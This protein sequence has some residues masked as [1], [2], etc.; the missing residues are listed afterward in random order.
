[1]M[2]ENE[3]VTK[4]SYE[5]AI[6][7]IETKEVMPDPDAPSCE[8]YRLRPSEEAAVLVKNL[9]NPPPP[10][11]LKISLA[12]S[13]IGAAKCV[14]IGRKLIL[15]KTV[16]YLDLSMC[17]L[18]GGAASFFS[19]LAKNTTLRH[20]SVNGNYIGDEGAVAASSSLSHLESLHIASNGISDKGAKHLSDALRNSATLKILNI[21]NNSL[22]LKGLVPFLLA[23]EPCEDTLPEGLKEAVAEAE[24]KKKMNTDTDVDKTGVDD[25]DSEDV[26]EKDE[27]DEEQSV[28]EVKY[29]TIL[30]TLWIEGNEEVTQ[31]LKDTLNGILTKR[32]PQL[33]KAP[34]KKSKKTDSKK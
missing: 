15:N 3:N 16:T 12:Q 23:L 20:L 32:V 28:P 19:H 25:E 22:T 33:P 27:E 17:D 11:G 24:E 10:W 34:R 21:R 29:N 26:N 4:S 8:R 18:R 6:E 5:S 1:M 2:S 14:H 30:H 7:L 31:Q 13:F 9:E